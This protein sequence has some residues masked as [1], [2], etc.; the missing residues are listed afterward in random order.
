[1]RELRTK[2]TLFQPSRMAH[3]SE[4]RR[5]SSAGEHGVASPPPSAV[6]SAP[7]RTRSRSTPT[8]NSPS[9]GQH[10]EPDEALARVGVLETDELRTERVAGVAANRG[11]RNHVAVLVAQDE[12]HVGADEGTTCPASERAACR[13]RDVIDDGVLHT[14]ASGED[15][16]IAAARHRTAPASTGAPQTRACLETAPPH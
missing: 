4:R 6:A 7:K 11:E 3:T 2:L 1:M 9:P 10:R 13:E 16:R 8:G 12:R 15:K 14:D 5:Q